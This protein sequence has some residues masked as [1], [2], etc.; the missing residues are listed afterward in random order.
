MCIR[1]H[2]VHACCFSPLLRS[3]MLFSNRD[4]WRLWLWATL[5][6]VTGSIYTYM[7]KVAG[8]LRILSEWLMVWVS[9]H[10]GRTLAQSCVGRQASWL[11]TLECYLTKP[12]RL[13]RQGPCHSL[14]WCVV[15][16]TDV[17]GGLVPAVRALW[18]TLLMRVL[19]LHLMYGYPMV[20]LR[21]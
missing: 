5:V 21:A 1:V 11:Q 13:V 17:C 6:P 9:E 10:L 7:S 3:S 19:I 8:E 2:L 4:Y 20:K 18:G 15:L 16:Y 14:M 12:G